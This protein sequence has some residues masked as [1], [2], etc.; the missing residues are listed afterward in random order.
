[1]VS[2]WGRLTH[3]PILGG[4]MPM[5]GMGNEG[6]RARLGLEGACICPYAGSTHIRPLAHPLHP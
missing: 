1:M 2:E 6:H 4:V 3:E 5:A